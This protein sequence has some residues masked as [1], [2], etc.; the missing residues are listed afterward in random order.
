M[1]PQSDGSW[2]LPYGR[3][4]SQGQTLYVGNLAHGVDENLLLH[5]FGPFGQI[6]NIQVIRERDTHIS[7]G[8]GFVTYSHPIYAQTAMQ[9]MDSVQIMGPFEGRKLKVSF[10]NRR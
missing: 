8:Y 5:Y 9:N 4:G 10:S 3:D 6:T 7:R 1:T 2:A